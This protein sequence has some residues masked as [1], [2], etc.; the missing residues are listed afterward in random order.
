MRTP[1]WRHSPASGRGRSHVVHQLIDGLLPG[2]R[3][4]TEQ[5]P[6]DLVIRE[7]GVGVALHPHERSS[8]LT[9][10][11]RVFPGPDLRRDFALVVAGAARGRDRRIGEDV[12]AG[13]LK[14]LKEGL[15]KEA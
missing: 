3:N 13:I 12:D 8:R 2:P 9:T 1:A 14:L 5:C 11:D 10:G 4:A 7:I 15:E 6:L